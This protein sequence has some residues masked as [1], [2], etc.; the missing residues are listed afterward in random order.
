VL[1]VNNFGSCC[2]CSIRCICHLS[3]NTHSI[4]LRSLFS[5][6]CSPSF[7]TLTRTGGLFFPS[8]RRWPWPS[9]RW[10][11]TCC[12]T[13]RTHS[14]CRMTLH[15]SMCTIGEAFAVEF[16]A[17][18]FPTPTSWFLS[19]VRFGLLLWHGLVEGAIDSIQ[20]GVWR[21]R[22]ALCLWLRGFT[23]QWKRGSQHLV[24]SYR[25]FHKNLF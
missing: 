1:N 8:P 12:G 10:T 23:L 24:F 13:I 22:F 25:T 14:P 18:G 15:R 19:L 5:C 9:L 16:E 17:L 20:D 4:F 11:S 2:T 7:S 3:R 21:G 6:S